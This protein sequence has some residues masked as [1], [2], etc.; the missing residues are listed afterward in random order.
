MEKKLQELADKHK[1]PVAL[2][3]EAIAM[4]KEKIVLSNRQLVPKLVEAIERYS[5]SSNS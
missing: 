1:I 3:K 5:D 2:L 4:E